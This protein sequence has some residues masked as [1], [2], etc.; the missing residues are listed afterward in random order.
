LRRA[1]NC[2]L[3]ADGLRDL[4]GGLSC[5]HVLLGRSLLGRRLR[6]LLRG[7]LLRLR[8]GSIPLLGRS[9]TLSGLSRRRGGGCLRRRSRGR[10]TASIHW[11]PC[12]RLALGYGRAAQG[13]AL[14]WWARGRRW[15]VSLLRLLTLAGNGRNGSGVDLRLVLVLVDR[16]RPALEAITHLERSL[17]LLS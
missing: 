1:R 3:D 14:S 2:C 8:G 15:D 17:V 13:L 7:R 10:G 16:T 9:L 6:V 11:L 5:L 12:R 4:D